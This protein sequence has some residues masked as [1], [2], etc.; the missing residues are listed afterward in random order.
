[1]YILAF[2]V[3]HSMLDKLTLLS[4]GLSSRSLQ[5]AIGQPLH[6]TF[7][8]ILRY[9]FFNKK[10]IY[11][12]NTVKWQLLLIVTHQP[13]IPF[14]Q[15]NSPQRCRQ[16]SS[17]HLKRCQ[18]LRLGPHVLSTQ[19]QLVHLDSWY[20]YNIKQKQKLK[21]VIQAHL[22]LHLTDRQETTTAEWMILWYQLIL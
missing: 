2:F 3:I 11:I 9:N 1:M 7:I 17:F 15:C 19:H 8:C 12:S 10:T 16:E 20:M 21:H 18:Q 14:N 5:V 4:T 22:I 13:P 6:I